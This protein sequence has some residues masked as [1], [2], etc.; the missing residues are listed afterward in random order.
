MFKEHEQV[1]L[2]AD[3]YGD[4]GEQL[5]P[6]AVGVI[7]H[8]HAG[9]DAYVVEFMALD[10]ATTAIATVLPSQVGVYTGAAPF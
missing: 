1:V 10:G 6:G 9:G 4:E 7:I 5:R 3:V 8:I 2:T